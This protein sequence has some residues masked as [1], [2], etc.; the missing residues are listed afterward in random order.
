MQ[1]YEMQ[2]QKR[3]IIPTKK[4]R[5][6]LFCV[7]EKRVSAWFL[8][9][10]YF[11]SILSL[12][13]LIKRI[14]I[15][16]FQ[17]NCLRIDI[18]RWFQP[19]LSTN[20]KIIILLLIK[21]MVKQWLFGFNG[22]VLILDSHLSALKTPLDSEPTILHKCIIFILFNCY[23]SPKPYSQNLGFYSNQM[24]KPVFFYK[25]PFYKNHQAQ[26]S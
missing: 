24:H 12:V 8:G 11:L 5:Y 13:I 23:F 18:F 16:K 14:L 21:C 2:M 25:N 9:N 3:K 4:N 22:D 6:K 26:N 17:C 15:K 10:S 20:N 7:Y 19:S 1:K